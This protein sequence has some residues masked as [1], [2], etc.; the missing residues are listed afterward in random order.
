M[1]KSKLTLQQRKRIKDK[2]S[3]LSIELDLDGQP[4]SSA[5]PNQLGAEQSGIVVTRFSNQADVLAE[6]SLEKSLRR[7][8]FRA[9]LDSLVTGDRVIWQ[10]G[11]PYGVISAVL[12]RRS[13]LDRPDS[14]G[15][16][17]TVVAN[18]DN[19]MV[20]IAPQ[21][22]PKTGLL[23]RYLI[24]IEHHQIS[25]T[26]IVNKVD[27]GT[28]L[29]SPVLELVEL[30]RKIGYPVILIS[31]K[32]GAGINK[33]VEIL[34][35][36]TSVFVGQ[37]GVGKSSII[38]ILCP[39]AEA[40]IGK[41]STARLAGRH[42]TTT[43]DL[44]HLPSGGN[45][46]DSPGIREFGMGHLN[47]HQLLNGF[48]EFRPYLGQCRFRNC[49]HLNEPDCALKNACKKGE[50]SSQRLRSFRNISESIGA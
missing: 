33:L 8:Y 6:D 39:L 10:D 28:E 30:Y 4:E 34:T 26:I 17:N 50:I 2:Q 21:P 47:N 29:L 7:C 44:Y 24:A 35:A 41:L 23:D 15:Q 31:S 38:N 22:E 48:I 40:K 36:K 3:R 14:S 1:G 12:P 45:I 49:R 9:H 11:D 32:S 42:T 20:V 43:A 13:Q 37:S 19:V 27:L 18:I 5:P 25:P 46:I 16:V